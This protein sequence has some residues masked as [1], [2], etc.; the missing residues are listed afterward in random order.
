MILFCKRFLSVCIQ[1][2]YL[3]RVRL[4]SIPE[5]QSYYR[6]PRSTSSG[7]KKHCEEWKHLRGRAPSIDTSRFSL[8]WLRGE[9]KK[10]GSA[11]A[12]GATLLAGL[13]CD[14]YSFESRRIGSITRALTWRKKLRRITKHK[15]A[16]GG[17]AFPAV[18]LFNGQRDS[19][20]TGSFYHAN[21]VLRFY[22]ATI[23]C[24]SR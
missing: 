24:V 11:W 17:L 8:A 1:L 18:I 10:D 9:R 13:Q 3:F 21:C 23:A 19:V 6:S 14:I 7:V 22:V 15:R 5:N 20:A 4:L 2:I 16:R 12:S